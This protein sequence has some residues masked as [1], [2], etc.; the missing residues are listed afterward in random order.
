MCIRDRSKELDGVDLKDDS[1][2]GPSSSVKSFLLVDDRE[3]LQVGLQG[4]KCSYMCTGL[5]Y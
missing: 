2:D 3:E 5:C 1:V 4:Y